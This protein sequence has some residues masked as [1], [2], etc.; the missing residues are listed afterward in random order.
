MSS[1]ISASAGGLVK[2]NLAEELRKAILSGD[3]KPGERIVEAKWAAKFGVA[4]ASI[5]EAIHILAQRGIR[6]QSA[7]PERACDPSQR[8]R[9]CPDVPTARRD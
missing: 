1:S 7:W 6:D 3:L 2:N 5:R 9:R 4:Q 8:R